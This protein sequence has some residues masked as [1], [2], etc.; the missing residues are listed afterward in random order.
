MWRKHNERRIT[1][2]DKTNIDC[3]N[4]WNE[5]RGSQPKIWMGE[6]EDDL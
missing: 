5:K 6:I 2:N 3:Q 1:K 4:E